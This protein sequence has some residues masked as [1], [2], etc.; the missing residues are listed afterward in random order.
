MFLKVQQKPSYKTINQLLDNISV[1][2]D[3]VAIIDMDKCH[4]I[5]E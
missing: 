4:F 1:H 5:P 2:I 3:D